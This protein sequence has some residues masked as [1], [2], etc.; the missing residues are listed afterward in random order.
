MAAG[1]GSTQYRLNYARRRLIDVDLKKLRE[2]H[3][4]DLLYEEVDFSQNELSSSGL[5][6]VLEVCRRCP[7]LRI[8]KLYKNRIDDAGAEGLADLCRL[9]PR[10]EEIHLSHNH[11]TAA[12]VKVLVMAAEQSRP[13]H[14]S[15]LWLRLEQNDVADPD[16]VFENLKQELSVCKRADETRCTV[17]VCCQKQKV[18]L[19]FFHLQRSN[20]LNSI[21]QR[22]Q[23]LASVPKQ[24]PA[25]PTRSISRPETG[26]S[27]QKAPPSNS[28]GCAWDLT[29]TARRGLSTG[30]LD[31]EPKKTASAPNV[32]RTD[33]SE[34]ATNGDVSNGVPRVNAGPRPSV[35]LDGAGVRRIMPEQLA[36]A[37]AA[38]SQFVCSLCHFVM[39]RPVITRCSHLFC[40][41]CFKNWVS[42]EVSKMKKSATQTVPTITC[43]Q[44]D[45]KESL[46][47]NDVILMEQADDGKTS[48]VQL[49]QRLRN[50][51]SVRCVHH[52]DHDQ[53]FFGKDS[54]RIRQEKGVSCSWTG[55]P[56]SYEDHVR[57]KC[58]VEKILGGVQDSDAA[59]VI[60][61]AETNAQ[62][63]LNEPE[64]EDLDRALGGPSSINSEQ[65]EVRMVKY[66]YNPGGDDK[67]QIILRTNDL[68]RIFE[69]MPTGWASGV[70]LSRQLQEV[71]DPGWFPI[72]YLHP[73]EY[74]AP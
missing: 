25:V 16:T 14:V 56:I 73:D 2:E 44:P 31:E 6:A 19:P 49:L 58:P 24:P 39:V 68:V 30:S 52:E 18:H 13:S 26:A 8:L 46:R 65:G 37:E 32:V 50:N 40:D 4:G 27:V 47:K 12:G 10:I 57:T 72:A 74:T 28:G 15:P 33:L 11:F 38:S 64:P 60:E 20:R 71:G 66:D 5:R 63:T 3:K 21:P 1:T 29:G 7:K 67:A 43:P 23:A 45:C 53:Y 55:D 42:K 17:R 59:P 69:I 35:V 54:V 22:E 70:R 51:L 41:P 34:K 48:A 61:G 36:G 9:I 62:Q